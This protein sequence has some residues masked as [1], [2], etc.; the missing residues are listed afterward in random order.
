[1]NEV[2][3]DL[4]SVSMILYADD[5]VLYGDDLEELEIAL[6]RISDYLAMRKLKLNL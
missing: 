1:L 4:K 3:T 5:I 6:A 2:L